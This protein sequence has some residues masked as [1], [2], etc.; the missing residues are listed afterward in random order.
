VVTK[1]GSVPDFYNRLTSLMT[2]LPEGWLQHPWVIESLANVSYG[3]TQL[4]DRWSG[5]GIAIRLAIT[6]SLTP[7]P[8]T[9]LATATYPDTAEAVGFGTGSVA[10]LLLAGEIDQPGVW[11]VEQALSTAQ[12]RAAMTTRGFEIQQHWPSVPTHSG[13]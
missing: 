8:A 10:Q 2:A 1:F 4:T 3:M 6:G 13:C 12:F 7:G 5:T 9:Y 11:P